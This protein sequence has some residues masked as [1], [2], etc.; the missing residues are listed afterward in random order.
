MYEADTGALPDDPETASLRE[1]DRCD[2]LILVIGGSWGEITERKYDRAREIN[3]PCLVYERLAGNSDADPEL[4][5]FLKKLSGPRGVPSRT[6]FRN[7]VDLAEKVAED[8]QGWL[9]REYRRL[10]AAQ[11][12]A[13]DSSR[14]ASALA[15]DLMRLAASTSSQ[16]ERGNFPDLLAWQLRQWFEALDYPLQREP[17]NGD[18]HTDLHILVPER[19]RQYKRTL[20]RAK[21]GAIEAVDVENAAKITGSSIQ[22]VWLVCYRRISPAARAATKQHPNVLLY[23]QDELIEEDVNFESYFEW[24]DEQV[25]RSHIDRL[26]AR[27]VL[28]GKLRGSL[29]GGCSQT[30]K[31][32]VATRRSKAPRELR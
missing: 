17:E 9:V 26:Q 25:R 27:E 2:V 20:V 7:A 14:R 31:F 5:R 3:K 22:E 29:M 6:T 8:V 11:L 10:S 19:R 12:V 4:T 15:S 32:Q 30:A 23:T 16:L 1:L 18:G 24:L 13:D 21:D 28:G